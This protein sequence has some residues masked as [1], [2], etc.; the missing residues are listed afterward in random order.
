M[1]LGSRKVRIFFRINKM[2]H[3]STFY[4]HFVITLIT[5]AFI[6]DKL[7]IDK[8]NFR[9][10]FPV[11]NDLLNYNDDQLRARWP[12]KMSRYY[13]VHDLRTYKSKPRI[14]A[15]YDLPGELGEFKSLHSICLRQPFK[16]PL[17][18]NFSQEHP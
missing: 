16:N 14:L 3:R 17:N 11:Q 7:F 15:Q 13:D 6:I 1:M 10:N 5:C 12:F 8:R 18:V 4:I 2:R 9:K